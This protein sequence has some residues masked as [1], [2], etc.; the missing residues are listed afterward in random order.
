M[1]IA[2]RAFKSIDQL[3]G[4]ISANIWLRYIWNDRRLAWNK[5]D[6]NMSFI[7]LN[8]HP[9]ADNRIWVPDIYLYNTAEN[10]Y[11]NWTL[12]VQLLTMKEM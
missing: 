6:Y 9:E 10:P 12:V 4:T 3:D 11:Q 8:T 7:S 2:L 1:G 5:N